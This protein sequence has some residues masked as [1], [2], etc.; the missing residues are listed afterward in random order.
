MMGSD[1]TQSLLATDI[2]L[3]LARDVTIHGFSGLALAH[4]K[5]PAEQICQFGHLR[6]SQA[7]TQMR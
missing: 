4:P 3:T 5:I 6:L 2:D 1:S 7:L